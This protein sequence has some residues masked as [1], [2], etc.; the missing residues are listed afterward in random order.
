LQSCHLLDDVTDHKGL[1]D[2]E[3]FVGRNETSPCISFSV[4][5]G[6]HLGPS[7]IVVVTVPVPTGFGYAKLGPECP[8]KPMHVRNTSGLSIQSQL[9]MNFKIFLNSTLLPSSKMY[10][11][12]HV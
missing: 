1:E 11:S 5:S 8:I 4:P 9:S 10:A 2:S 12:L 3:N 6:S 7:P